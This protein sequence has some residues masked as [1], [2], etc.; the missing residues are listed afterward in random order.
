M[1][2][3]ER[4]SV[5]DYGVAH[6]SHNHPHFQVLVGLKGA[7]ELEVDGRGHRVGPGDGWVVPPGARHDFSASRGS[8]CLVLDSDDPDWSRCNAAPA[9][10]QRVQTLARFLAE[11]VAAQPSLGFSHAL[12]LGPLLLREAWSDPT[13]VMAVTGRKLDWVSLSQWAAAHWHAELAVAD[14][15]AQVHLSSS[16]FATRCR[17]ETGSSPMQWLRLQRLA[18][19]R[20]LQM[21][22]LSVAESARRSGYRSPSALTAALRRNRTP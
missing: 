2:V 17:Q 7:L 8:C 13:P 4:L 6:G 15:A 22:G 9:D 21:R 11:T 19:A 14:L 5:R 1:P 10:G 16:Q 20:Q 12:T 18:Q 3:T